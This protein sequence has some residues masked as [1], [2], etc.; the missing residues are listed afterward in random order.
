MVQMN[1]IENTHFYVTTDQVMGGISKAKWD[2]TKQTFS[3]QVK[4]ENNGGFSRY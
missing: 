1:L 4:S 2:D 3:G